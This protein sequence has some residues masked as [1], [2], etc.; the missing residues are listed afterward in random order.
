MPR[1]LRGHGGYLLAATGAILAHQPSRMHLHAELGAGE[2]VM[3]M[4]E[5]AEMAAFAN[6]PAYGGGLRVAPAAKLDDGKL[7]VVFVRRAGRG[8]LLRVAPR[9][10][11]GRHIELPEVQYC[12]ASSLTLHSDPP[13][14]VYADGEF[15]CRTPVRVGV[16]PGALRVISSVGS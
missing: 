7:E 13:R 12:R 10:L 4:D 2:V 8:R 6:G 3:E 1:W 11:T 14:D 5:P 9:I 16:M 15:V